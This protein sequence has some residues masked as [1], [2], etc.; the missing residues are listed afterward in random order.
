MIEKLGY[1][2]QFPEEAIWESGK[3]PSTN[4][5]G[6]SRAIWLHRPAY[7]VTFDIQNN[8]DVAGTEVGSADSMPGDLPNKS[9]D[10]FTSDT[11]AVL[12]IPSLF[13]R[14]PTNTQGIHQCGAVAGP[15][16][17]SRDHPLQVPSFLLG[18]H[19]PGL[20]ETPRQDRRPRVSEQ[21]KSQT[22]WEHLGGRPRRSPSDEWIL[23]A[24]FLA[25]CSR[26]N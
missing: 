14:A 16:A 18:R 2:Q 23:F 10:L 7:R 22:T 3:T 6:A 20:E 15:N 8:G 26:K 5:T 21:Q 11:A 13:R 17:T 4:A 24:C 12:G 19:W 9:P 25:S 1:S